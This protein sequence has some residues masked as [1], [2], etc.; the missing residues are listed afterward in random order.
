V[1]E[2]VPLPELYRSTR[3]RLTDF[4]HAHQV[5]DAR[6]VPATPGWTVHDVVA[7]LAGLAQDLANGEFP[8]DGPTDAW[9]AGHVERGRDVATSELLTRWE[10]SSPAVEAVLDKAPIWPVVLDVAAHEHDIRGAVGDAG[11]R[12]CP[13]VQIGAAVMLKGLQ[14]PQPLIVETE[15]REVRVG[16]A[17][18]DGDPDRLITSDFEAFRWRLGRRSRRQLAAMRWSGDPTPY[19]DHLCVFGPAEHDVVE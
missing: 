7:H 17:G 1:T 15:H 11:A 10:C 6:Q 13:V 5:P 9:T 8:A 4:L 18:A 19:L 16:P 2:R 3:I 14:L 12:D